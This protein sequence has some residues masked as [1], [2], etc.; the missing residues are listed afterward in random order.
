MLKM[1]LF[2][3]ALNMI[4]VLTDICFFV[5]V[6]VFS[7]SDDYKTYKVISPPEVDNQLQPGTGFGSSVAGVDVNNDG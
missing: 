6:V 7:K 4:V 1:I 5:Q 3:L 2:Q